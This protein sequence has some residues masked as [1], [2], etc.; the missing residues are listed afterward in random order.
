MLTFIFHDVKSREQFAA[1]KVSRN[2]AASPGSSA[3]GA[4]H[5]ELPGSL[6]GITTR[7]LSLSGTSVHDPAQTPGQRTRGR[8]L[9]WPKCMP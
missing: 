5:S 8:V 7:S 2:R 4:K 9:P 1:I 6:H 3:G